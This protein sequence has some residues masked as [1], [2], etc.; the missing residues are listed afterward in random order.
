MLPALQHGLGCMLRPPGHVS[1]T[2]GMIPY[3][4]DLGY[5]GLTMLTLHTLNKQVVGGFKKAAAPTQSWRAL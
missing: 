5:P 4:R 3:Y 1:Y 2:G